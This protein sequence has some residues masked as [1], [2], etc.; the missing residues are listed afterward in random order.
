MILYRNQLGVIVHERSNDL[1]LCMMW[2]SIII[3]TLEMSE[4]ITN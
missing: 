2:L 1:C 3:T 4:N